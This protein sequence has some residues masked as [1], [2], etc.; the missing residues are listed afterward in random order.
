M[1]PE[2]LGERAEH[3]AVT[4]REDEP[5][6]LCLDRASHRGAEAA[7]GA[8]EQDLRVAQLHGGDATARAGPPSGRRRARDTRRVA[9][10]VLAIF[11]PTAVGKT[12]VAIALG[13]ALRR[14]G[15]APVA[16]G[17]D[18]LQ[19]YDGLRS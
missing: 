16:I 8:G 5:A 6:A 12:A 2:L 15:E 3:L 13:D 10:S 1:A 19:V 11:G 7:G 9:P 17:V 4:R 18:A 14:R